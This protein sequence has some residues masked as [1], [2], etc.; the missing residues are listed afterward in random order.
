M[1][2]AAQALLAS[3]EQRLLDAGV[4]APGAA[5]ERIAL[6]RVSIA[7]GAGRLAEAATSLDML[8]AAARPPGSPGPASWPAWRLSALRAELDCR[9]G[10]T[11]EGRDRRD[12]ALRE[13]ATSQPQRQRLLDEIAALAPSCRAEST[14]GAD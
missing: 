9:A 12:T 3:A 4:Q 7:L 5:F 14:P 8:D 6:A 10:R 1:A 13:A 2:D 11:G